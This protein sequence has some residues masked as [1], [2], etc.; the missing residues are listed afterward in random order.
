[1]IATMLLTL[2]L[3]GQSPEYEPGDHVILH[4]PGSQIPVVTNYLW[5][6]ESLNAV[7]AKD[8]AG[9]LEMFKQG[10][11]TLLDDGTEAP[12]YSINASA[13]FWGGS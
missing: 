10:K 12:R 13:T 1:M 3:I 7:R 2:A 8:E 5:A 9:M 11:M 6:D 4:N